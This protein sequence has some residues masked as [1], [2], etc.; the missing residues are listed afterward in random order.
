MMTHGL[1]LYLKALNLCL[2]E[3]LRL[4][5]EVGG[6]EGVSE[7]VFTWGKDEVRRPMQKSSLN[8]GVKNSRDIK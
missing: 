5:G 6:E 4:V 3:S 8:D 1:S 2:I 7:S